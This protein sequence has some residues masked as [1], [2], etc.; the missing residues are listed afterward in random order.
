M[1]RT[2][3][4]A[5][6]TN[7]HRAVQLAV[8]AAALQDLAT[9]WRGVDPL[10]LS[11]TIGQFAA[12]SGV[13]ARARNGESSAVAARY[14][15]AFRVAEGISGVVVPTVA[16]APAVEVAAGVLRGAGLAGIVNARKGGFSPQA[17]ARNGF[18][19]AAGSLTSLVL[20]G[21]RRTVLES[22][23]QD[24]RAARWQRVTSGGPCGFCTMLAR[25]G[26]AFATKDT[27]G[28]EPHDNCA[29]VPEIAYEGSKLPPAS[30]RLRQEWDRAQE[31]ARENGELDRGTGNDALNALRRYRAR[32]AAGAESGGESGE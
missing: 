8:R 10:D 2:E 24:P 13:V 21:A 16:A 12:A 17:A 29:C 19:R 11:G 15:R 25:R 30:V 28:F 9:L 20:D 3:E 26:P 22:A 32:A 14:F 4:G 7:Q 27:A 31:W 18:V 6:L 23:A 5:A 1:A